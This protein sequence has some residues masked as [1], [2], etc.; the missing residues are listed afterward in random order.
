MQNKWLGFNVLMSG[1]NTRY[2]HN[3]FLLNIA[4][5]IIIYVKS[6]FKH[7]PQIHLCSMSTISWSFQVWILESHGF[8][9]WF[10]HLYSLCD[11]GQVTC[12]FWASGYISVKW[13]YYLLSHRLVRNEVTSY[14]EP[15]KV[16]DFKH[17]LIS[18]TGSFMFNMV[19]IYRV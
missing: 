1:L 2:F 14:F 6:Q 12:C 19:Q 11:W 15:H 18:K 17:V 7:F 8:E 10:C 9:P 16:T 4:C 5:M 13:G 3:L